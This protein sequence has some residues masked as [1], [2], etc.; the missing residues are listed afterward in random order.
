M[1]EGLSL[2]NNPK[3]TSVSQ[4]DVPLIASHHVKFSGVYLH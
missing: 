1:V 4:L 3:S 2:S